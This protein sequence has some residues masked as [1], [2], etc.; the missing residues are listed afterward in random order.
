MAVQ[1]LDAETVTQSRSQQISVNH[2][3]FLHYFAP[4]FQSQI[5][6]TFWILYMLISS[7]ET[8]QLHTHTQLALAKR[9]LP[10]CCQ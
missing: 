5:H 6:Y 9:T 1:G 10:S 4:G 3:S 7:K 8:D 2:K